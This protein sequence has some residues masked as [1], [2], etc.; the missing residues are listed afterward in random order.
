MF[1]ARP[2]SHAHARRGPSRA[3]GA[4]VGRRLR[5]FIN[6]QRV[7][8]AI[9]VVARDACEAGINHQPHAVNRQRR[10]RDVRGD[11]NFAFVVT[12]NGSIL[13][14]RRQF[15][16]Q[17]QKNK[18]FRLACVANGF[19]GL[20]DFKTAR[21]KDKHV[22]F[23]I[24]MHILAECI[25]RLLPDRTFVNVAGQFGVFHFHRKHPAFG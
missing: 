17:R 19:N 16:V 21:H 8:A 15:A 4:L 7:D 18:S 2:Q 6:Q 12:R 3:T 14:A 25:R 10:F 23:A 5:D 22:A 9:R 11:D 13:I 20:R 24:A 1:L